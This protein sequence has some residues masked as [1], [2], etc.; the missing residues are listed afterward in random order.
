MLLLIYLLYRLFSSTTS[1]A[2]WNGAD[3]LS[4]HKGAWN[5]KDFYLKSTLLQ[6]WLFGYE[7][8]DTI[9]VLRKDGHVWF[10]ATKKKCEFLRPAV[11]R[12]PE[13]SP[14]R[15]IHLLLRNK[16]DGN[17]AN[18][19]AL[20]EA[21]AAARVNGEK[22]AVGVLA[23]EREANAG[24]G[25]M[26]A[27]WEAQL[28]EKAD[29]GEIELKDVANGLSFAQSVKDETELDLMKKSSVLS[30]K[31]MKHGYVKKM[32]EVIDSE[33]AI[34]HEQLA[35]FVDEILEDPSK[36]S[37]KVPKEDVQACYTP[38]IQSGGK[39]DLRVSAQSS[40]DKLSHDVIMVSI[41]ARYRNYCSN[42]ARTFLVDPPQKVTETYEVLLEVQEACL[43][44]MKPG[45]QF[46][47]VYKAA[48]SHLKER[49]GYEYLV[50]HLPKNLGFC[51]GLD[52]RESAMLLSPKSQVTFKK[53]MTFCLSVGFQNLE[54]SK[55]DVASTVDKSSVRL[56][57]VLVGGCCCRGCSFRPFLFE[58]NSTGE[59]VGY[60]RLADFGHGIDYV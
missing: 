48:V 21:V 29:A 57:L 50:E 36:I 43:K 56:Y 47:A 10:L 49:K 46:K 19:E 2:V 40:G 33:E 15:E 27:P 22:R 38:I 45:N 18:Y 4:L 1:A 7:L 59:K 34:T 23:K 58:F 9:M 6:Q 13:K 25:G 39:Y 20:W 42:I 14:I 8:P 44:A 31:V 60:V 37:L 3:V 54:L 41:G 5:D 16:E 17:A 51:T 24:T 12:V 30:N 32:E 55:A 11:A 35:E 53:G 28:T 52:F 26:L